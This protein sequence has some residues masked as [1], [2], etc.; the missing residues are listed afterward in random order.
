MLG[1]D[2]FP[3]PLAFPCV[4]PAEVLTVLV[5]GH[6]V[7]ECIALEQPENVSLQSREGGFGAPYKRFGDLDSLSRNS[8]L[9]RHP[10]E[11]AGVIQPPCINP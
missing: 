3:G 5:P 7:V 11:C 1:F 8:F 4:L 9:G 2:S 6:L 10:T